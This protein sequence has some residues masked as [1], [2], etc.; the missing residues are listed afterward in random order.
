MHSTFAWA[1]EESLFGYDGEEATESINSSDI[2]DNDDDNDIGVLVHKRYNPMGLFKNI[3]LSSALTPKPKNARVKLND[4]IGHDSME[5]ILSM[6]LHKQNSK[7][8][9]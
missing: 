4:K 9:D 1:S 7:R 5:R 2:A 3:H 8:F 6:L